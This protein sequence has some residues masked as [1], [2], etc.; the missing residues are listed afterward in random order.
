MSYRLGIVGGGRAAWAFGST[1]RRMGWPISGLAL[2][3]GSPSTVP[4]LLSAARRPAEVLATDSD[5]ILLAVSDRAI[6]SVAENFPAT[7]AIVM[8]PSGA[9]ASVRNGFSLHPL[10]VLAAPGQ[11]S[12]LSDSLLVFEGAH[13]EVADSIARGCGA[14][15][16]EIRAA[17]KPLYHAA[18]VFA[19]NYAALM[20]DI[21]AGLMAR[22]GL[23]SED[24]RR[25]LAGLAL[26]A[27]ENW[28]AHHPDPS[29]FTGPAARGDDEILDRHQQALQG[30]ADL[31]EIYRLLA[32]RIVAT[33]K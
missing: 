27:I 19:S 14:R 5:L 29:R 15:L 12:D 24:I 21:A 25:P 11:A 10:K 8:H 28:A 26:S 17:D 9:L 16:A 32:A 30:N 1:W 4:E 3:P 31:S 23:Q 7:K 18:A 6:A 20:L 33:A 2:R 13:R 22:T